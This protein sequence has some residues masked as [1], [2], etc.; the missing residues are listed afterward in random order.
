MNN[1][2]KSK[3]KSDEDLNSIA[4]LGFRGEA[5]AAVSSV[6]KVE[7]MTA[8]KDSDTGTHYVIEGS[9]EKLYEEIDEV[10][11]AYRDGDSVGLEEELGDLLLTVNVETPKRLNEKQKELG[12]GEQCGIGEE[13]A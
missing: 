12:I 7:I 10:D 13:Q 1:E 11:A 3:I 4:T 5:L 6:S 9:E 8:T 2:I